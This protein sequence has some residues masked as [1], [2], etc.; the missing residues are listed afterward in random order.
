MVHQSRFGS[1]RKLFVKV[2]PTKKGFALR[3]CLRLLY[4]LYST[5]STIE[6][7]QKK[8]D[9]VKYLFKYSH[10]SNFFLELNA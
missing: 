2:I 10:N 5:N 1:S 8:L 7:L 4:E 6:Q 3:G 9:F